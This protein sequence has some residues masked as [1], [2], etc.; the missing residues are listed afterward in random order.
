MRPRSIRWQLPLSY[1]AIA[2]LST[3]ALGLVLLITLRTYYEQREIGYLDGNAETINTA[4]RQ[5]IIDNAP[6]PIIESHI[7]SY[8]FLSQ[9]RIRLLEPDGEVIA[10]SGIPNVR[11]NVS[12]SAQPQT[13]NDLTETSAGAED[14]DFFYYLT[15]EDYVDLQRFRTSIEMPIGI[16]MSSQN[17]DPSTELYTPVITLDFVRSSPAGIVP[18]TESNS[19]KPEE[20]ESEYTYNVPATGTLYGFGLSEEVAEYRQRSY[21]FVTRELIDENGDFIGTLELSDGPAY[22]R[23]IVSR[24]ASGLA[25]A[26]VTAMMVAGVAGWSVSLRIT[27]PLS[28]L[29]ET[30]GA[31]AK[32]DLS[33]RSDLVRKDELGLLANSFNEMA[34]RI[35]NIVVTLRRFVADAAHELHTPITALNTNL[36][37]ALDEMDAETRA[38]YIQRAR[39]QLKRLET[40]TDSLLDLSR[41]ESG[42]SA[43]PHKPLPFKVMVQEISELYA[44]R[45]EQANINFELCLPDGAV[46]VYGNEQQLRSALSNLMDNAIKFTPIGETVRVE[47]ATHDNQVEVYIQDQGIGIPIDELDLIFSRFHRCRNAVN[48]TGSGLGLA[49]V[50]GVVEAHRGQISV[51]NTS[52]GTRFTLSLPQSV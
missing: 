19:T 6:R 21:Q 52:P 1:A 4:V 11:N 22:G 44:S 24:V 49:I 46:T 30:T 45:S 13:A 40:L 47:M 43:A 7:A 14:L 16:S 32:G 20:G 17:G 15:P 33:V 10:D 34:Q 25:I 2:L 41:I 48:F 5:M 38:T 18:V 29:T 36:E 31:M 3:L 35:E 39:K 51:A 26:S 8:S 50:R 9:V 28:S 27:L 12:I 37:L 42:L 23:Q